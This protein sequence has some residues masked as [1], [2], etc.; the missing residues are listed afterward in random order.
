MNRTGLGAAEAIV[1]LAFSF[2]VVCYSLVTPFN[3]APDEG[4]HFFLLEYLYAFGEFPRPMI[5]PVTPATSPS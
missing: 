1:V 4:T 5:D 2:A 3:G